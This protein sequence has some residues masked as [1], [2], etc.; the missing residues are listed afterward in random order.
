MKIG[1]KCW[2]GNNRFLTLANSYHFFPGY[3]SIEMSTPSFKKKAQKIKI[4]KEQVFLLDSSTYHSF[5]PH[6]VYKACSRRLPYSW[7]SHVT[8]VQ[9][10]PESLVRLRAQNIAPLSDE[11]GGGGAIILKVICIVLIHPPLPK[12]FI[13]SSH[14]L[15]SK[16]STAYVCGRVGAGENFI[17]PKL[18]NCGS[19]DI[20]SRA[21][22]E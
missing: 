9:R 5:L 21:Q 15:S 1:N 14:N 18:D 6:K 3:P 2:I 8:C 7:V 17:S 12:W 4:K 13:F 11:L 20:I 10:E 22:K 16:N 19:V